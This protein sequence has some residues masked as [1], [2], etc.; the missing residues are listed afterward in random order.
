MNTY[1][2]VVET[3]LSK[4]PKYDAFPVTFFLTLIV[5]IFS[6]SFFSDFLHAED[7]LAATQQLVFEKHEIWRAWTTL[8][9]HADLG[10]LM[11]N[12]AFLIPLTFFLSGYFGPRLIPILSV[13]SG[14]LINLVVLKTMPATTLLIGISGVVYWMGSVWLSLYVLIDRRV[15]LRRRLAQAL[16][17]SVV[18]FA[19]EAYKPEVSYLSHLLGFVFGVLCGSVIYLVGR[20]KFIAAETI[21]MK[22][23]EDPVL[24]HIDV[25][26]KLS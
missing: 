8:F 5:L 17:L 15:R 26:G 13:L 9:V 14:G 25:A 24:D 7:R 22:T 10:H 18:L 4:K 23:D 2:V 20:K 11:S 6:F 12:A 16:F 19:P 3:W 21:I 1:R